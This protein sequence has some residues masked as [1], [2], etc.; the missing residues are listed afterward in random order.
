VA[1]DADYI[2]CCHNT[3]AIFPELPRLAAPQARI[4]S[5]VRTLKPVDLAA[6][7]EKS[8]TFSWEGMFTRSTFGTD[9]LQSQHDLLEEAAVLIDAGTLVT[10]CREKLGPINAA[11]LKTAHRRIEQGRTIGKLVLEG[12]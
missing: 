4:C 7:Q 12:F 3:D 11:N 6:L 2:L 5:I 1:G 9:D 8:L 10:T